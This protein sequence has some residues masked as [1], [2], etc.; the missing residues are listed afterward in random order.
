[1]R[2]KIVKVHK[3]AVSYKGHVYRATPDEPQYEDMSRFLL[4]ITK[5][6]LLGLMLSS[7]GLASKSAA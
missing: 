1:M 4:N 3:R 7:V 2:G 6:L 5:R